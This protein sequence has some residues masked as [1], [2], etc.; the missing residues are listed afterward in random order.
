MA[1][2]M[3]KPIYDIMILCVVPAEYNG[4]ICHFIKAD[5]SLQFH[6]FNFVKQKLI[7]FRQ[8]YHLIDLQSY[9]TNKQAMHIDVRDDIKYR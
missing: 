7:K 3:L 4:R 9:L 1:V 6:K 5:T 8:K 2:I